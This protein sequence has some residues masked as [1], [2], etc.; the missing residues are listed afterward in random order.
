MNSAIATAFG[1]QSRAFHAIIRLGLRCTTAV[2]FSGDFQLGE[3]GIARD[4]HTAIAA[5]DQQ[6]STVG[7]GGIGDDGNAA[8]VGVGN[9]AVCNGDAS[10]D[11]SQSYDR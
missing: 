6:L 7:D 1:D 8:V 3:S 5:I 10:G 4:R 9:N 11:D 2:E